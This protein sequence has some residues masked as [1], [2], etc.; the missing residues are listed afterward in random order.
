M[1]L[2]LGDGTV[3]EASDDGTVPF[4][5][6]TFF[7]SDVSV[8]LNNINDMA[9]FKAELDKTVAQKGKNMFYVVKVS[10]AFEK[11]L[12]RSE[13]KQEKPYYKRKVIL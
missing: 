10:G 6:V 1:Y 4:S 13:L 7:D 5:N 8:D 3:N 11:M 12:V 2:A 9:F